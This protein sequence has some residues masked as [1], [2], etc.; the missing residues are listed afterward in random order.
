MKLIGLTGG[1]ACGKST[2]AKYFEKRG[3][4]V[5]YADQ[6][7]HRVIEPGR[8]AYKKIVEEFG[9]SVLDSSGKIDRK[10]LGEIVFNNPE[11]LERLNQITHPEVALEAARE[12][13]RYR[14]QGVSVLIYEVPLLFEAGLESL[15]DVIIT[16]YV[17]REVQRERLLRRHPELSPEEAEKRIDSQMPVDEKARR[18]DYILD[19]T[20]TTEELFK[21][22]DELIGEIVV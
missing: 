4:P 2:A 9:S 15:F 1:I 17:P 19:N 20:G 8:R 21:Q 3:I 5:I 16:V 22:I 7:A 6:L 10:K 11:K 13:A 12:I 14:G 18:S